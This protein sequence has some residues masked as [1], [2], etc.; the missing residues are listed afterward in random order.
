MTYLLAKPECS[1][2]YRERFCSTATIEDQNALRNLRMAFGPFVA[3]LV[4]PFTWGVA[5]AAPKI[6]TSDWGR[7]RLRSHVSMPRNVLRG[8]HNIL[9]RFGRD[10]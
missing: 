1:P 7:D 9:S 3:W 8:R 6:I 10:S 4:R 5:L 2:C